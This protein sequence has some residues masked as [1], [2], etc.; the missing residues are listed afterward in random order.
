[1]SIAISAIIKPSRLLFCAA[2][3]MCLCLIVLGV[4][5]GTGL[6]GQ[7]TLAAKIVITCISVFCALF[8]IFHLLRQKTVFRIDISGTGNI[9]L[10]QYGG[11]YSAA[12]TGEAGDGDGGEVA[13]LVAGSTLWPGM[14]FLRLQSESGRVRTLQILPDSVSP[15]EFRT[16]SVAFRWIAAR[17]NEADETLQSE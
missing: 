13:R 15:Q 10:R 9:R 16:L 2:Y 17:M 5:I 11:A 7:F 1:M 3:G 6:V 14:M 8:A 4:A 12:K